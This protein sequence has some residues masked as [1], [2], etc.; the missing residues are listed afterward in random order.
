[1]GHTSQWGGPQ[2][3]G[4]VYAVDTGAVFGVLGHALSGRFTLADIAMKMDDLERPRA[5]GLIDAREGSAGRQASFDP[6]ASIPVAIT[7]RQ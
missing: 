7:Q 4:N 2:R 5:T 1:M 6:Y 3:Y